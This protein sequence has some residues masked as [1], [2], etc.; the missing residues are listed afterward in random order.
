MKEKKTLILKS[1]IASVVV[2][3]FVLNAGLSG[4][5]YL[6]AG[7]EKTQDN[8]KLGTTQ[9]AAPNAPFICDSEWE[10]SFVY[11]GEYK[12]KPIRFRVLAPETVDYGKHT[13]FLDSES[14]LFQMRF[15][16]DSNV[17]ANSNLKQHLNGVFLLESFTEAENIAIARSFKN[18]KPF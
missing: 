17:W 3:M 15:D 9:I 5:A 8:T 7:W 10:G 2:L 11:F 18:S 12:G 4:K 1:C 16:D 6:N 14:N 13:I